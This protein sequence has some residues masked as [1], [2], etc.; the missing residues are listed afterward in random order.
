MNWDEQVALDIKH[1]KDPQP[2]DYWEDHMCGVLQVVAVAAGMVIFFDKQKAVDAN[3]WQWDTT[4][5]SALTVAD[6]TKRLQ[7]KSANM[8][9]KTWANVHPK[10]ED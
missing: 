5:P 9:E 3:H 6:F 2:G 4:K 8:G 10:R 7:Y 1:S